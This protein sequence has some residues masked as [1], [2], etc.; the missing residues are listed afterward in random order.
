[1]A[2]K[3]N[4]TIRSLF[5]LAL[6][7]GVLVF[8]SSEHFGIRC[9]SAEPQTPTA[10]GGKHYEGLE[11]VTLPASLPSRY[12]QYEGFT[13]S[14]NKETKNPNYV[15]WE[16]LDTETEGT[17]PRYD[18]FWQDTDIE[19]CPTTSDYTRSGYDRG[20]MC[21]AADQKWSEQAMFDCF[22]MANICPQYPDLNQKAWLTLENKERQWAKRDSAIMI[23]AGPIFSKDDTNCIGNAKVRVPGAFFKVL[24]A[25][26]LDTPRA[27]AF[28]YPNMTA[29]GNMQ[30]YAMSVDQ[31]E[32]ITGYD[33]FSA[34][35]DD[36]EQKVESSFSFKEWNR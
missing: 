20:H 4:R 7:A 36:I 27:I 6:L 13:L 19:N 9:T 14:F 25:P 31:L 29:P 18:K 32:E 11:K 1:M 24:L 2:R 26:Y 30:D 22:V 21:P 35:P 16:L 8:A 5:R 34:L 15:A 17:L 28:V 10:T 33:F 3:K 23:I 12:K